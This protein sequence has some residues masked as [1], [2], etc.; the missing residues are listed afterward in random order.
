VPSAMRSGAVLLAFGA[1]TAP[2]VGL[3]LSPRLS[4]NANLGGV[5]AGRGRR[6]TAFSETALN[7]WN[8]AQFLKNSKIYEGAEHQVPETPSFGKS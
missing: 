5:S 2:I 7:Q 4:A 6:L 8:T 3:G 1:G